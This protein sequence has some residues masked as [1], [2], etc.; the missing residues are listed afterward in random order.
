MRRRRFRIGRYILLAALAM[1]GWIAMREG[2]P[3]ARMSPLPLLAIDRYPGVLADLQIAALKR[4]AQACRQVLTKPWIAAAAIAPQPMRNGCGIP[5]G[6]RISEAGGARIPVGRISCE[7]AAAL[8][9]WIG[10]GVQPAAVKHLG[11]RVAAVSHY[12]TYACRNIRSSNPLLKDFKSEHARGNAIDIAGFRLTSGKTITVSRHWKGDTPEARFLREAHASAC[13]VFRVVLGPEANA[14][15][16][17]HF[18]FDRG[19]LWRCK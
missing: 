1:I 8:A 5:N 14:L 16:R 6:V 17:D 10:H 12:G 11:H 9:V 13:G 3:P 19:W 4:D 2:F 7:A 18:H 15:H